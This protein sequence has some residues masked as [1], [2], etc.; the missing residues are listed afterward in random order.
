M[1]LGKGGGTFLKKSFPLPSPN[2]IPPSSKLF[3]FIE[4][5]MSAFPS[6]KDSLWQY[7]FVSNGMEDIGTS[8]KSNR[9]R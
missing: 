8:K 5:L 1:E 4:S 3:G 2:P 9:E 6:K 7:C